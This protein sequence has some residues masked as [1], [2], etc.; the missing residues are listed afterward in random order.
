MNSLTWYIFMTWFNF[1]IITRT[2]RS[3]TWW[4]WIVAMSC[5]YP[6]STTTCFWTCTPFR[7]KCP[8]TI[9][10]WKEKYFSKSDF[11]YKIYFLNVITIVYYRYFVKLFAVW[12][13]YDI[14]LFSWNEEILK[15]K[16]KVFL[17]MLTELCDTQKSLK[18]SRSIFI[19]NIFFNN[20]SISILYICNWIILTLYASTL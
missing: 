7:P 13:I 4:Q 11:A 8:R 17:H 20:A 12:S 3:T 15:T 5:T 1:R 19:V 9:N 2:W 10:Y 6:I 18:Y 16:Q 14:F